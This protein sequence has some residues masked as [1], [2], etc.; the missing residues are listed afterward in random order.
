MTV[1]IGQWGLHAAFIMGLYG[2][3]YGKKR[4]FTYWDTKKPSKATKLRLFLD[5]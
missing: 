2:V 5:E 1:F 3:L 4:V